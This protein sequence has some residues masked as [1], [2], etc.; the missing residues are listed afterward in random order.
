MKNNGVP[1]TSILNTESGN[2][3][4]VE[5]ASGVSLMADFST[6]GF[7]QHV[8]IYANPDNP[9]SNCWWLF[10]VNKG[11]IIKTFERKRTSAGKSELIQY[12]ADGHIENIEEID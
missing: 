3:V 1:V 9:N 12:G 6:A 7:L 8:V 4:Y 11:K 5:G 10:D 2:S